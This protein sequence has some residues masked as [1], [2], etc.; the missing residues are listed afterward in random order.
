MSNFEE[1]ARWGLRRGKL[2]E[3]GDLLDRCEQLNV[4]VTIVDK[5]RERYVVAFTPANRCEAMRTIGRWASDPLLSFDW[6]DVVRM[7]NDINR[8]A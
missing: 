1:V 2:A 5:G 6:L 4:T 8:P 3:A 7:T